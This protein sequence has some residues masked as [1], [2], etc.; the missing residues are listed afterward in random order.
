[1]PELQVGREPIV[2]FM[3]MNPPWVFIDEI[4][5]FVEAFCSCACRG[6]EREAQLALAVHELMQN[7]IANATTADIE[8]SLAVDTSRDL[9]TVTVTNRCSPESAAGLEQRIAKMNEEPDPMRYY[10]RVMAESPADV[11]GGLGL[12]RVRCEADLE[13]HASFDGER[14]AVVASGKL[15]CNR[16]SNPVRG[17]VHA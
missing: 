9:V 14:I 13:L 11:R 3:R 16:D 10:V 2:L 7:A 17:T 1:M 6:K 4:R 12:A 8:L 15:G 5:R